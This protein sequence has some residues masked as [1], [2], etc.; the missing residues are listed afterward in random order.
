MLVG[1]SNRWQV[2]DLNTQAFKL[3]LTSSPCLFV[4]LLEGDF[5]VSDLICPTTVL[6]VLTTKHLPAHYSTYREGARKEMVPLPSPCGLL[7]PSQCI[8]FCCEI[9]ICSI[10]TRPIALVC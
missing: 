5:N 7:I 3:F 4:W 10:L 1:E 6:T 2:L 9:V 8:G